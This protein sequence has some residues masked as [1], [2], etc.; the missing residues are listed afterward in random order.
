MKITIVLWALLAACFCSCGKGSASDIPNVA[1]NFSAPL[2]D[3]R[4]TALHAGGGTVIV[5]D[6]GVAGLIIYKEF[7]GNYAA[8]D[9]CSTY[10]PQQRCAVNL[11]NN[12]IS[13]TDPCSGSKFSLSDGSP[14]KGPATRALKSYYVSVGNN[15]IFVSN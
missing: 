12:A 8:Y 6:Y 5:N 4:L 11:D 2:T 9:R 10:N 7:D 1:V 13:V 14:V 3:P 15:E